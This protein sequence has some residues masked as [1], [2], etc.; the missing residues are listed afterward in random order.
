MWVQMT[1]SGLREG[2]LDLGFLGD[3]DDEL[4]SEEDD[5]VADESLDWGLE[6]ILN[7]EGPTFDGLIGL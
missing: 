3:F 2:S 4:E 6:L 1:K 5:D 7:L